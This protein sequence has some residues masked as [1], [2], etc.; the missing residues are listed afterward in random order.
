[1]VEIKKIQ[2][3]NLQSFVDSKMYLSFADKPIS[4]SRVRSYINNP[5][6]NEDDYV[7]YMAFIKGVLVGYRTILT[8]VFF[9]KEKNIKFGWLSGN[10]AH[11]N[12]RRRG[13][14]SI[15]FKEVLKDWNGKLM[16]TNYA[17]ASKAVYDKTNE[18]NVLKTLKG[19]RY[20]QRVCFAILLPPKAVFFKIIK[21]ILVFLD[22]FSNLFLDI[23]FLLE[24]NIIDTYKINKIENWNT[25]EQSFLLNF[26]EKEFFQRD[27]YTYK[28]IKKYP[29]IRTDSQTKKYSKKY[30]F[31]SYAKKHQS[32]FYQISNPKTNKVVAIINISIK[33]KQLKIPYLY[34]LPVGLEITK[35]FIL[36]ICVKHKINYA[37]IYNV[38]LNSL[39]RNS[40]NSFL[41]QKPFEQ[42]Y[43]ATKTILNKYKKIKNTEIQTGDGD[44]VFT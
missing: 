13:I 41:T 28:W 7:L 43:F 38:Q 11:D 31:S 10:W 4:I 12:H 23:R 39:I 27:K 26:K 15:L 14:S 42:K 20:Y 8:D 22:W 44:G 17:E 35:K 25:K 36:K 5:N 9:V 34:V 30:Y 33:D 1:M 29:W 18:F 40:K 21:P 2:L 6:A 3:K 19:Y 24:K 16:Y 32:N 37:T